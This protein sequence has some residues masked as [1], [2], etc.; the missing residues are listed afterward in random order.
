MVMAV[1]EGLNLIP[2]QCEGAMF[3][4]ASRQAVLGDDMRLGK[5]VQAIVAANILQAK[6]ILVICPASAKISWHRHFKKW[7]TINHSYQIVEGRKCKI[8]PKASVIIVNY[9]LIIEPFIMDQL[10][11]FKFAIGICDEAH[12]LKGRE[13]KRSHAV[14]KKGN[15][16]SR[17]AYMWFLTGTFILN[18][19]IEMYPVLRAAAPY[20]IEPYLS[21][22]AYARHFCGGYF[23]GLIYKDKGASNIKELSQ[24][25][26]N[27]GFFLRRTKEEVF[28]NYVKPVPE[29]VVVPADTDEVKELMA[30]EFQW[31]TLDIKNQPLGEETS[32][33]LSVLRHELG[34][35]IV[36]HAIAHIREILKEKK[37]I[38]IFSYHRSVMEV[39]MEGLEEFNPVRVQG[40]MGPTAKQKSIDTFQNDPSCRVFSG[41]YIA[42]G[43][44][45]DLSA[46]EAIIHVESSWVPGEIDQPSDRCFDF[47]NPA[48]E[49]MVQFLSIEGSL[50]ETMLS[51]VIKKRK[52][53]KQIY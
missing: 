11:K 4:A 34:D 18:R 25:L 32:G 13:S 31:E 21:Y 46:G 7:S 29:L 12:K 48:K 16:G 40:G 17:C 51:A 8:N 43:E 53:I 42:A 38:V 14:L 47:N 49:I 41:Q 5:T 52:I 33:G 27:S 26:N 10:L 30:S 23:D 39:L 19:P 28:E 1:P 22:T 3:L 44:I 37:K 35:Y 15:L 2:D 24:R 45:I 20:I 36:P 50:H 9:D 6:T